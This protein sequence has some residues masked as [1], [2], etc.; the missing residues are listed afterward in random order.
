MLVWKKTHRPAYLRGK[1]KNRIEYLE[2][3]AEVIYM[4]ERRRERNVCVEVSGHNETP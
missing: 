2:R 4:R 3:E 1:K